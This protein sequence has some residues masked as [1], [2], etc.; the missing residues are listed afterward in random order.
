MPGALPETQHTEHK[1]DRR[2]AAAP[3]GSHPQDRSPQ[4]T[5]LK[6]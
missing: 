5:N 3:K 1:P 4:E 6:G 2:R